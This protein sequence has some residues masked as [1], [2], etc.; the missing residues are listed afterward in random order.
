[1][2]GRTLGGQCLAAVAVL[3]VAAP[4]WA[5][6]EAP[7]RFKF[8][9]DT[10][11]RY[12]YF[13]QDDVL[14]GGTRDAISKASTLRLAASVDARV[15]SSLSAFVE[16]ES[17]MQLWE[18][19]YNIPTIGY[20]RL[21]GY[22]VIADPRGSEINQAY[23]TYDL[24]S[25]RVRIGRQELRLNDGRFLN[26]S[27]GRQNHLS[28]EGITITAKPFV[29]AQVEYGYLTRA[30]RVTGRDASNGRPDM[31]SQFLNLAYTVPDV[32]TFKLYDLL[33]DY[34]RE[35]TNSTNTTGFRFEGNMPLPF[36]RLRLV[37]TLDYA[38]QNDVSSNP[39]QVSADY[40]LAELGVMRGSTEFVLGLAHIEGSS[41]TDKITTPQAS[42]LN[43]RTELF[44]LTPTL[45][46]NNHGLDARY[47]RVGTAIA[48]VKGLSTS[49]ILY[50]Y[51]PTTGSRHYGNEI[52]LDVT[53]KVA[54]LNNLM[55]NLRYSRYFADALFTD[56]TR[57]SGSFQYSFGK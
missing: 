56:A 53:Y 4:A 27:L 49:A 25:T 45:D 24:S 38:H 52:D 22:P 35:P 41:A 17:V 10:R 28:Y 13:S 36:E 3:I 57:M 33:L 5:Q 51:E 54:R 19:R 9:G 46:A 12:E 44:A 11:Y 55:F 42:P 6:D 15:T 20:Q 43:G 48:A 34:D 40:L 37:S 23:L 1:M 8:A 14:E 21:D 50:D 2:T 30:L 18:D 47:V 39:N 29:G 32:G 7:S 26:N 16:L 31:D